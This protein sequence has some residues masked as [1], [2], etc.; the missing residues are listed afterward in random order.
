ML[1]Y[2]LFC[3]VLHPK[4]LINTTMCKFIMGGMETSWPSVGY[5]ELEAYKPTMRTY[6]I[7]WR[8][9]RPMENYALTCLLQAGFERGFYHRQPV[10]VGSG[11]F[12][13]YLVDVAEHCWLNKLEDMIRLLCGNDWCCY[14]PFNRAEKQWRIDSDNF[15]KLQDATIAK[16]TCSVACKKIL[17][18]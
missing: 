7:G 18:L 9:P 10:A 5:P 11:D 2:H 1:L 17:T 3:V 16:V 4:T 6:L 15:D 8:N 14:S 13:L 12:P